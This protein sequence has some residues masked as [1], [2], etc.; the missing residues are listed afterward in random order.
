[1]S[2]ER[3]DVAFD[4]LVAAE[5]VR[6]PSAALSQR[7]FRVLFVL[8]TEKGAPSDQEVAKMNEWR[9]LLEKNFALATGGRARVA[10]EYVTVPKKRAVR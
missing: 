9:A 1:M 4:Q 8:V 10:T 7:L 5:G 2:G 3:H 6:N